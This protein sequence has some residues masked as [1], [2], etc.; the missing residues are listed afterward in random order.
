MI[1]DY[2]FL[3]RQIMDVTIAVSIAEFITIQ[4]TFRADVVRHNPQVYF[5]GVCFTRQQLIGD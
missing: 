5:K 2:W 4:S 1:E 3:R